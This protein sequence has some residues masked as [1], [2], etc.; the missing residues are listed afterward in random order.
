[1]PIVFLK[2]EKMMPTIHEIQTLT[3]PYI[4][5]QNLLTVISHVL[6]SSEEYLDRILAN[7]C[8]NGPRKVE[9]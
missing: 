9:A 7:A 4:L 8:I 2:C 6:S 1:M 5:W 3:L